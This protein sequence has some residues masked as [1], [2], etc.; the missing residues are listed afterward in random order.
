MKTQKSFSSVKAR[1]NDCYK[2]VIFQRRSLKPRKH[3]SLMSTFNF[4]LFNQNIS[5]LLS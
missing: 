4:K 2:N 5:I 3:S 1:D